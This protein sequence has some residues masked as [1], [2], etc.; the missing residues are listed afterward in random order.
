MGLNM[1]WTQNI[2]QNVF[3]QIDQAVNGFNRRMMISP[4]DVDEAVA[5]ALKRTLD[6]I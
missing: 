1:G 6:Q 4:K 5:F 3:T 2:T